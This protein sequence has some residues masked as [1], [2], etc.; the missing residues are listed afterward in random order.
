MVNKVQ[1][2]VFFIFCFYTFLFSLVN[3]STNVR[4]FIIFDTCDV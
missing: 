2:N 1:F 3:K 4:D